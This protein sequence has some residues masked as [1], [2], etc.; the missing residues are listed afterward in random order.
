MTDW[1]IMQ[2]SPLIDFL[3]KNIT[4]NNSNITHQLLPKI[5]KNFNHYKFSIPPESYDEFIKLYHEHVIIN[6]EPMALMEKIGDLSAMYCDIDFKYLNSNNDI[7]CKQ[8]TKNTVYNICKL[9][10]SSICKYVPIDSNNLEKSKCFVMEKDSVSLQNDKSYGNIGKDGIH[11]IFPGIVIDRKLQQIIISEICKDEYSEIGDIIL[12]TLKTPQIDINPK[13]INKLSNILDDSIYK[14]G[15]MLM[16]GS[17]KKDGKAYKVTQLY[18]LNN[19]SNFNIN[20][21][22]SIELKDEDINQYDTYTLLEY[23]SIY[24]KDDNLKCEYFDETDEL[25]NKNS[26]NICKTLLDKPN[27]TDK[28]KTKSFTIIDNTQYEQIKK[29]NPLILK[30]LEIIKNLVKLLGNDRVDDYLSWIKV[31]I[32]LKNIDDNLLDS[33]IDLSKRSKKYEAGV[34]EKHWMSNFRSD[35]YSGTNLQIGSLYY[36]AKEDNLIGFQNLIRNQLET[37][38]RATTRSKGAHADIARVVYESAKYEY[39]CAGI[40]KKEWFRFNRDAAK[41]EPMDGAIDLRRYINNEITDIFYYYQKIYND[42]SKKKVDEGEDGETD[43]NKSKWCAKIFIDLKNSAFKDNVLKECRDLYYNKDFLDK[44]DSNTHLFGMDNCIMDL[45]K[46]IFR[47]GE[48]DDY[49]S[50][51][52]GVKLPIW[53]NIKLPIHINTYCKKIKKADDYKELNDGLND[54]LDKILPINA[55]KEY[56]IRKLSS[57]LSGVIREEKFHIWTGS[58]GNGKS[59][60]IDLIEYCFGQYACKLPVSLLTQKRGQSSSANPELART[61]GTRF[62]SLQE[63]NVDEKINIGLMKEL[64]GGDKITARALFKNPIDFKP[65]FTL[66]LMCNQL[67][68]VPGDDDGTWRRMEVVEFISQFKEV[69][70]DDKKK[71]I[72]KMDT[73]LSEKLNNWK[74]PFLITLFDTYYNKYRLDDDKGGGMIVPNDVVKQTKKYREDNDVIAKV[75]NDYFEESKKQ[76][77]LKII[78]EEFKEC[79]GTDGA[80]LGKNT[81]PKKKDFEIKLK[82]MQKNSKYGLINGQNKYNF[83]SNPDKLSGDSAL[84]NSDCDS[85][86]D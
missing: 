66:F 34:C 80:D 55:V 40:E 37:F 44:L 75:F 36:W 15:K 3:T 71:N 24:N 79:H 65:Q 20:N 83:K 69:K 39:V 4:K 2:D 9:L 29:Y 70:Y 68:D 38:V 12:S 51:S 60:L 54:F 77:T 57:C 67:P 47:K 16:L 46:G 62:I 21:Y 31:G 53:G 41:W 63:P 25:L 52:C 82:K 33:W 18:I 84:S 17:T 49:V 27:D 85:D 61:R 11:I 8:F 5:L 10:W 1:E 81:I 23:N 50:L 13:A 32:C 43:E 86:S 28:S 14:N 56:T 58:G 74:L 64:T 76:Y 45:E 6:N 22:M 72:F 42:E 30:E 7:N 48:P 59:K 26:G 78:W 19:E 73:Q 35:I